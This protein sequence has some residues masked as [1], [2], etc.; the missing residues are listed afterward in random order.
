M[1]VP[2][3]AEER[4]HGLH[5]ACIDWLLHARICRICSWYRHSTLAGKMSVLCRLTLHA[6]QFGKWWVVCAAWSVLYTGTPLK[7][8]Y[9]LFLVDKL[10]FTSL[11]KNTAV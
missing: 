3:A 2:N 10:F 8:K 7:D 11:P 9:S 1:S 6:C 4:V 5:S